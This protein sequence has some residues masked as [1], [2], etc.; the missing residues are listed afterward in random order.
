VNNKKEFSQQNCAT[1][2]SL[3]HRGRFWELP[4]RIFRWIWSHMQNGFS[5]WIRAPGGIV[6]WKNRESKISWHW[7]FKKAL[8]LPTNSRNLLYQLKRLSFSLLDLNFMHQELSELKPEFLW[9]SYLETALLCRMNELYKIILHIFLP[10][11]L[12][13]SY[14]KWWVTSHLW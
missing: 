7:P 4:N 3:R 10:K 1:A 13:W 2:V 6:W 8:F 14:F 12:I 9:G 5:S 11:Y